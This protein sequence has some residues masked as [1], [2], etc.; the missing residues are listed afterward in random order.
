MLDGSAG[1]GRVT[2]RV[3]DRWPAYEVVP[4][5]APN[6]PPLRMVP[7]RGETEVRMTLVAVG[8]EWRIADAERRS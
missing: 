3:V 5:T 2:L 1:E 6:G 8:V 4:A 7:E